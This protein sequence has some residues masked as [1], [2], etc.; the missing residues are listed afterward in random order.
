MRIE[1]SDFYLEYDDGCSRYDLY[2]LKVINAKIPEKRR[3]EFKIEA[4]S[5]PLDS[6]IN[7]IIRFRLAKRLDVVDLKTFMDEYR[8][9]CKAIKDIF[10]EFHIR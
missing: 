10:G 1:E 4:Y 5:I 7:R 2:F 6:A 9:E 3:E 8:K